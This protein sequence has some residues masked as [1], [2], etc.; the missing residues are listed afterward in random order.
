MAPPGAI[1]IHFEMLNFCERTLPTRRGL[2]K[3]AKVQHFKMKK[4]WRRWA[5]FFFHFEMLN[6]CERTR[7]GV[8]QGS[9]M[10]HLGVIQGSPGVKKSKNKKPI[11]FKLGSK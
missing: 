6:L 7:P 4:T 2:F 3:R 10:G 1:F 9:F 11:F 8:I 5:P